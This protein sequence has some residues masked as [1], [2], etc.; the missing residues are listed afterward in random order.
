[1]FTTKIGIKILIATLIGFLR[2]DRMNKTR[3]EASA[4]SKKKIFKGNILGT[5]IH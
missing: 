2:T 4:N 5:L 1:M 3:N